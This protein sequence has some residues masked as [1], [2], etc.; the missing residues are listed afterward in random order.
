MFL[1]SLHSYNDEIERRRQH[2]TTKKEPL[3]VVDEKKAINLNNPQEIL[4]R[5]ASGLTTDLSFLQDMCAAW[6]AAF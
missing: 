2:T 3:K 1:N 4:E 6:D 5:L